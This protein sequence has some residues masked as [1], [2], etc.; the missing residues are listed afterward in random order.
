MKCKF[1][2]IFHSNSCYKFFLVFLV[3]HARRWILEYNGWSEYIVVT[4]VKTSKQLAKILAFSLTV[5]AGLL[6]R[7][8]T[9]CNNQSF[10]MELSLAVVAADS[11]LWYTFFYDYTTW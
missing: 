5:S 1:H 7:N 2:S 10:S 4:E 8:I 3:D 9:L 6:S 11:A